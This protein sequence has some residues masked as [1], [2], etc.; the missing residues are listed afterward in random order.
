MKTIISIILI[1]FLVFFVSM[2]LFHLCVKFIPGIVKEILTE[3]IKKRDI[4]IENL[5]NKKYD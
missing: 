4:R 5:K 2:F 1:I 3:I